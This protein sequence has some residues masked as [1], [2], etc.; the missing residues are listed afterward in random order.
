MNNPQPIG[1]RSAAAAARLA[2]VPRFVLIIGVVA[3]MAGGLLLPGLPG[4]LLLGVLAALTGW[5]AALAWA[6][7]PVALRTMRLLV[8]G[9]LAAAAASKLL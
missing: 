9:V 8:V 3:A 1:P 6:A 4:A 7:Q 2:Q 5:L